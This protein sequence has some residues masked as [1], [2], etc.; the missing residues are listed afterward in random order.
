MDAR[1]L[2]VLVT[3]RVWCCVCAVN[4]KAKEKRRKQKVGPTGI[5][6]PVIGFKVRGDNRYTIGPL[7]TERQAQ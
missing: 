2:R 1:C 3:V 5:R 6:T 7:E 4:S